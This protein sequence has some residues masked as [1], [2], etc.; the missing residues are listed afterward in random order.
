MKQP[1][2]H[3]QNNT[4]QPDVGEAAKPQS[5]ATLYAGKYHS[6]DALEQGYK[7]LS[8]LVREKSPEVPEAYQLDLSEFQGEGEEP[9]NLE[10][11]DLW[12]N[13]SPAM[14]EAG[15][16]NA[17]AE[18]VTK[19]FMGYQM[20]QHAQELKALKAMGVEGQHMVHQVR[21][22]IEKTL[23]GPELSM[24]QQLTTTVDGVKFLN[25]VANLAGE[26]SIPTEG[27]GYTVDVASLKDKAKAMMNDPELKYKREKQEAY[28]NIWKDITALTK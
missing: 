14:R 15:L 23:E 19:A 11:D 20:Q 26:K 16:S 2:N 17:Q 18:S 13:V 5:E 27:T 28:N 25:K 10:H 22:F 8:R 24:A 3:P 6:V 9:Y 7:E 4:S 1:E 21:S 12:Q